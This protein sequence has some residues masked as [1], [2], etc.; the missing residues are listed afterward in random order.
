MTLRPLLTA[1]ALAA[2]LCAAAPAS[3]GAFTTGVDESGVASGVWPGAPWSQLIRGANAAVL[4]AQVPW[5]AVAR[6]EPTNPTD[7]NDPAYKW[8]RIDALARTAG[9]S[10]AEALL[11]IYIAPTWAEG[12]NRPTTGFGTNLDEPPFRGSW[13][14]DPKALQDFAT[15]IATRYSGTTPDPLNIALMLPRIRLFEAWNEPNYKMFLTPQYEIVK[16]KRTLTLIDRYRRLLNAFYAGIKAV[17]PDATVL[18]AGLGPYGVSSNGYE[19][20]PQIFLRGLLCIGRKNGRIFKAPCPTRANLDGV[21][22]HPYTFMGTALTQAAD[23]DGAGLGDMPEIMKIVKFAVDNRTSRP[24]GPKPVYVTEFGWLTNPPGRAIEGSRRSLGISP[25]QAGIY[26]SETLY[27]LWS[28]GIDTAIWYHLTDTDD[29]PGGMYFQ[30]TETEPASPKP[31]TRGFRFPIFA[32]KSGSSVKVWSK[33]PCTGTGATIN[34]E[35][36][37]R[38]RWQVAATL[39]PDDHGMINQPIPLLPGVTSVRGIA[40]SDSGCSDRSVA[41]PIYRK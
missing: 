11:N 22:H 27:R 5:D 29:W 7:P 1:C 6:T 10:N 38:S 20:Q 8:A 9:E 17:Q 18:S 19:I 39:T 3:A 13:D 26:T 4:R 21:A 28:W 15:A 30:K 12:P 37:I 36:A 16:G 32:L 2:I 33:S 24:L 40:S 34:V 25:K 31:S 35:F 14:P 23:V 41:M